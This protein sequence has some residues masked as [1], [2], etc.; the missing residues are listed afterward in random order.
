MLHPISSHG[1]SGSSSAGFLNAS[2][3]GV[4]GRIRA[5][6]P[7]TRRKDA[8]SQA[9]SEPASEARRTSIPAGPGRRRRAR[10][11]PDLKPPLQRRRRRRG[12]SRSDRRIPER[13]GR[14]KIWGSSR[15]SEFPA[16]SPD[17]RAD[18]DALRE[19]HDTAKSKHGP[20]GDR[21]IAV[22]VRDGERRISIIEIEEI[23]P[24]HHRR[25]RVI[26]NTD[27]LSTNTTTSGV[28]AATSCGAI[29]RI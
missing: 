16:P 27:R 8:D 9:V 15:G 22:A 13:P 11:A 23:R 20:T 14:R 25:L 6:R 3:P 1:D 5:G 12:G 10:S 18:V 28:K 17:R 29:S 2:K 21:P 7:P 19:S 24:P 26:C 4:R